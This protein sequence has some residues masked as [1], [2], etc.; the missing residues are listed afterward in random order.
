M[1]VDELLASYRKSGIFFLDN[2]V[3]ALIA[4]YFPLKYQLTNY[5]YTKKDLMNLEEKLVAKKKHLGSKEDS[6]QLES[7]KRQISTIKVSINKL[8]L[9]NEHM[10]TSML[11]LILIKYNELSIIIKTLF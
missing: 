1:S 2:E 9:I 6:K 11:K 8:D 4:Y 3:D 7:V 10:K 5:P